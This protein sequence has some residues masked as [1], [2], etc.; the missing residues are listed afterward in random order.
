M[1]CDWKTACRDLVKLTVSLT[2]AT[3]A[4]KT[5]SATPKGAA[6][7]KLTPHELKEDRAEV[8]ATPTVIWSS[9]TPKKD[10]I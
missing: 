6:I 8:E 7:S 9:V 4:S 10:A 2:A 3:V 5:C 1:P